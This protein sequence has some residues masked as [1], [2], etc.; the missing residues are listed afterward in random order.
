MVKAAG[1][2]VLALEYVAAGDDAS[3]RKVWD[4]VIRSGNTPYISTRD[5][6]TF[7]GSDTLPPLPEEE[8]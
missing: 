8:E 1:V 6:D 7:P 2:P 4:A 5:L 3:Y